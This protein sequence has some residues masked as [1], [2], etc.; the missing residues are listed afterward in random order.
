MSFLTLLVSV[1]AF[2]SVA[3]LLPQIIQ[4]YKTQRTRDLS[5]ARYVMVAVATGLW[6]IYFWIIGAMPSFLTDCVCFV[7]YAYI[8]FKKLTENKRK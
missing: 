6:I 1:A 7:L 5:L 2:L 4:I 3:S 8:V